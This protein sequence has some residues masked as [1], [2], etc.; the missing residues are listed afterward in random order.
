MTQPPDDPF[1][2]RADPSPTAWDQPAWGLSQWQQPQPWQPQW[3]EPQRTNVLAILSLVFAL[4]FPVGLTLG[5]IALVQLRSGREKG[6]GLAIAG[7]VG[8]S[9]VG[10]L[11]MSFVVIGTVFNDE[12]YGNRGPVAQAG[13]NVVGTCMRDRGGE[14]RSDVV[15]CSESHDEE[16]FA[17]RT[18]GDGAWPGGSTLNEETDSFCD[19]R[20]EDYV[21]TGYFDSD[22]DYGFYRPDEAEWERG[23]RQVICVLTRDVRAG[24]GSAQGSGR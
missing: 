15:D 14:V 10:L 1:A 5:I 8:S 11:V 18:E 20:F 6:K 17:V 4:C 13:S 16:V 9:A 21:G 2:P 7:V 22:F 12:L 24:E 23:E 19:S 3:G